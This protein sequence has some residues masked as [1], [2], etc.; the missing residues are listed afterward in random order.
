MRGDHRRCRLVKTLLVVAAHPDLAESIR[1][2]VPADQYRVVHRSGLEEAEPLLVHGL[3]EV[4]I[5]DVELANVQGIWAFEKLHRRAPKC[6]I[7]VY[8]PGAWE[9]EEEAYLQG[10]TH[11]L[12]KP[13]R[14]RMLRALLERL[15]PVAPAPRTTVL[16]PPVPALESARSASV[17]ATTAAQT[18]SVLRDFSGIL[19]HSLDSEGMLKQFLLLLRELLS[20]NRA[21]IFLR[22]PFTLPCW[23]A[24]FS[25]ARRLRAASA[26]GIST[27]LLEHFELSFEA[28]IGAYLYRSGRILR[29]QSEEVRQD[30]EAQKEFELFGGQ[31]AVPILDRETSD[32]RRRVRW[33][34][35]G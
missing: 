13:V 5:L 22:Q 12:S 6:P 28:G 21:A 34:N 8:T 10:A 32:R 18:L 23:S 35:H 25:E 9:W 30:L 20:I 31:V 33:P 2:G 24:A 1:A 16:M 14:P 27:G 17:A 26:I 3:A 29:V 15:W 4:C 11:V 7:I 19:T